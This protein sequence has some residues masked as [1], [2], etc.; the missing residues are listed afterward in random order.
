[1][2]QIESP[3]PNKSSKGIPVN[4]WLRITKELCKVYLTNKPS[5]KSKVQTKNVKKN[6]QNTVVKNKN[7]ILIKRPTIRQEVSLHNS[8]PKPAVMTSTQ[9]G[10]QNLNQIVVEQLKSLN[11]HSTAQIDRLHDLVESEKK[12]R[13]QKK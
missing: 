9:R 6:T 3:P 8:L 1:V 13:Q 10:L 4:L 12:R 7:N 5:L 11:Q 2:A